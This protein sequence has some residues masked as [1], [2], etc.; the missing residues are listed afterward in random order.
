MD[1]EATNKNYAELGGARKINK[2]Y[3]LDGFMPGVIT[4]ETEEVERITTPLISLVR[5]GKAIVSPESL[6]KAG[7]GE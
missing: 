6:E 2:N 3:P 1:S 7:V 4:I 5:Q